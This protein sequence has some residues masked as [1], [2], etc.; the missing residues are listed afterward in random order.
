MCDEL[1]LTAFDFVSL[2]SGMAAFMQTYHSTILRRVLN[3]PSVTLNRTIVAGRA[4]LLLDQFLGHRQ[5]TGSH[6][7]LSTAHTAEVRYVGEGRYRP[8]DEM[9]LS[10]PFHFSKNDAR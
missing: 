9:P 3:D 4:F 7:S 6:L 1:S 5:F 2:V 10:M 8:D